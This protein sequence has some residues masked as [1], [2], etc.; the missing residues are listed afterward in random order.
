M[1]NSM[2][3]LLAVI[4]GAGLVPG[5]SAGNDTEYEFN[6]TGEVI[7]HAG[8]L[9]EHV[10]ARHIDVWLPPGYHENGEKRY[11]VLYMH[12]GQNIFDPGLSYTGIDWDVD[13]A[14]TKLIESGEIRPAIV[15]G[16][17]N[18]PDRFGEYM[19]E[20][21]VTA[22]NPA[23]SL[24][25]DY[26]PKAEAYL[27]FLSGELVPFINRTYRTKTGP[28]DTVI[29][30]SSMGGLISLYALVRYPAIFGSAGCVS[31][32]WPAGDGIV[33][34]WVAGE[35]PEPGL[36]RFWF[37]Y[38]TEGVDANYE[39]YQLQMDEVMNASGYTRGYDWETRRYE[40]AGHNEAAWR[41]RLNDPLKFLLGIRPS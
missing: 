29:M 8:F 19:P 3:L 41:A 38:G 40:G 14:M 11:P 33:I 30:G 17:W 13:G 31:T 7:R 16:I 34:E 21:A 24:Y 2:A 15:V 36:H 10:A 4:F 35:L 28:E 25:P 5:C 23:A 22:I 20:R 12:D 1:R 6:V 9:S 26:S 18:S 27:S 37:D 39:P 32:H